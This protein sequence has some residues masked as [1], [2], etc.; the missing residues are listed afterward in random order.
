M[1]LKLYIAYLAGCFAIVIVPGPTVTLIVGNSLTHGTRAGLVNV[2]GTQA[3]LVVLVAAVALGMAPVV[4]AL[5]PWFDWV[6]LIGAFYLVW[7]GIKFIRSS[8]RGEEAAAPLPPRG[9]FFWQGFV[10]LLSNPKALLLFSAFI[11]QFM[12]IRQ[13]YFGQVLFLGFTFMAVATVL[14][15]CYVL[16]AGRSRHLLSRKRMRVV[17]GASGAC[18]IS[19]GIWLALQRSR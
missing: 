19:G 2:A 11:P 15:T 14:D 5:G 17:T 12:D 3:A 4:A 16:L 6:R 10:V 8:F 9:G 1:P 13:D 7:L 18:L